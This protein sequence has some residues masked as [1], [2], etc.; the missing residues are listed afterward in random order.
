[1]SDK[2]CPKKKSS[3]CRA[4]CT[5]GFEA[6]LLASNTILIQKPVA[7]AAAERPSKRLHKYDQ[8]NSAK[9]TKQSVDAY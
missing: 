8:R 9:K 4:A 2:A 3:R 6:S 5:V 7:D 1:M